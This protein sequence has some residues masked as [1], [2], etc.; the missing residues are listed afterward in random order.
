MK[1]VFVF[2]VICAA[3]CG[4]CAHPYVIKMNNGLQVTS[5]SKPKLKG[6]YYVYTDPAGRT[7]V[8]AA[9]RVLEIEP[10]S[11]AEEEKKQFQPS[12]K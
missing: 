8:V 5:S 9:S 11:M 1:R 10:A 12:A 2:L 6:G 3:T 7:A 4:G